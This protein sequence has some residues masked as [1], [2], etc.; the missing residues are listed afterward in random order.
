MALVLELKLQSTSIVSK[1]FFSQSTPTHYNRDGHT[2][3]KIVI[4]FKNEGL[5]THFDCVLRWIDPY[6]KVLLLR[7]W[8][9][10][11]QTDRKCV[12]M[13]INEEQY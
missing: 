12:Y 3:Q 1:M 9:V 11:N 13:D 6:Q 8:G 7:G 2:L 5:W 10:R 4:R